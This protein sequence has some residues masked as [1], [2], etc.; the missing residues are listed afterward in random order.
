M[1]KYALG[2]IVGTTLI[3]LAKNRGSKTR[4][5]R[6]RVK[7]ITEKLIIRYSC[8]EEMEDKF[9]LIYPEI[10]QYISDNPLV[11]YVESV[12]IGQ[13]P[14]IEYSLDET[15]SFDEEDYTFNVIVKIEY[16][17]LEHDKKSKSQFHRISSDIEE[18]VD[19]HITCFDKVYS[20]E[21]PES[22]E[23]VDIIINADTGEEYKNTKSKQPK[24]RKR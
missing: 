23:Y 4:L 7:E 9:V 13:Y 17:Y 6:K 21:T 2:T 19:E 8:S 14:F 22:V 10:N 11:E 18:I 5:T 3:G 16:T 20:Y 24:L 1:N 15:Y 12:E